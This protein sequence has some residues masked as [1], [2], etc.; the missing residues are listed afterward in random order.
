MTIDRD[1]VVPFPASPNT[2][3]LP[4]CM[5]TER[6]LLGS[7]MREGSPVGAVA[8]ILTPDDFFGTEHRTVFQCI[9]TMAGM[10]LPV[11]GYTV[12]SYIKV[13]DIGGMPLAR[14][15]ALLLE[16]SSGRDVLGYAQIIKD[17]SARR[18]LIAIA[19]DL[20]QR[21]HTAPVD[22][23][24]ALLIEA[25]EEH[26]LEARV[27]APDSHTAGMSAAT[28]TAWM[29]DR[30]R[31]LRDGSIKSSAIP[32]GIFD[33]DRVTSGGF[34]RGQLWLMA[35]RPGMGKT[36]VMTTL[37]RQAARD[38]GVLVFQCEVTRDQ[39]MARYLAD[40]AYQP[41]YPL[42]FGKIMAAVD[43]TGEE[44]DRVERAADRFETL[45]LQLECQPGVS[46]AQIAFA[47]KAEKKRLAKRGVRLGVVFID[48]LKFITAGDRYRGNRV[49]EIGEISGAL[50]TLAKAEDIC[51]VLL[52]QLNR[53]V[54][55]HGRED[56]RP[57]MADL[58]DSGELEQDADVVI[59]LYRDAYYLEKNPKTKHDPELASRLIDKQNAL[60]L[61]LGKNRAGPPC[62]L[63]LWCDVSASAISSNTRGLA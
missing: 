30:M 15:L 12:S 31:G 40:L 21:A 56:R 6:T 49:L 9:V 24:A 43:L 17:L 57:T 35:G 46:L 37:S 18:R 44:I 52:A 16:Q 20:R 2:A 27:A 14:Y 19:D 32:S 51:V 8:Q 58:R 22:A 25:T 10:G 28:A 34:Q 26:L 4:H 3:D 60:E 1:N 54:E 33:L 41:R 45:N 62:T 42:P 48:Y 39:Q 38:N 50:K 55:A 61:I 47:V 29:M 53:G 59:L 5:E 7:L 13:P 11:T 23:S 63:D 36:V